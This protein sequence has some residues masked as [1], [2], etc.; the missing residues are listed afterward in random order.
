MLLK[1]YKWDGCSL[2][3]GLGKE[4][5]P[6]TCLVAI[7]TYNQIPQSQVGLWLSRERERVTICIVIEHGNILQ[8]FFISD[9][10]LDVGGFFFII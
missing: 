2:G 5:S 9:T 6:H 3:L 8:I 10:K 7:L 4:Y 1:L